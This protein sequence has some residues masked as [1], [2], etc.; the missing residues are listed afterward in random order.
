MKE[1]YIYI[2]NVKR[3]SGRYGHAGDETSKN[4]KLLMSGWYTLDP[5]DWQSFVWSNEVLSKYHDLIAK[6]SQLS[7]QQHSIYRQIRLT[8]GFCL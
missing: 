3:L 5:S 4:R 6:Y 2:C 8:A 1:F 7:L